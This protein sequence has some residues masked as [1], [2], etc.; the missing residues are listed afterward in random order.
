MDFNLNYKSLATV[1]VWVVIVA[2]ACS[3]FYK[4]ELHI[5]Q[6]APKILAAQSM[7]REELSYVY[8][9]DL[10]ETYIDTNEQQAD[11]TDSIWIYMYEDKKL[12]SWGRVIIYDK[13][14]KTFQY[15]IRSSNGAK[16]A[17]LANLASNTSYVTDINNNSHKGCIVSIKI[18]SKDKLNYK[19]DNTDNIEG[20]KCVDYGN[21]Q[22]KDNKFWPNFIHKKI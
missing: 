17:G 12:N 4:Q 21:N 14:D 11:H 19:L 20:L 3:Y 16:L 1:I 9:A 7:S 22:G 10:S 6:M 5:G 15:I 18:V 2:G 13:T 8:E